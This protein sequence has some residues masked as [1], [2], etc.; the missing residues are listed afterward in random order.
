M[1]A[2]SY[3]TVWMAGE[4]VVLQESE[5]FNLLRMNTVGGWQ[6]QEMDRGESR[7]ENTAS[8]LNWS[9]LTESLC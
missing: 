4:K 3:L 1:R 9:P 8:T 6:L 2:R 5:A 7:R